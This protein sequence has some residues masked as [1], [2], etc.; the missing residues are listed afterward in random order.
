MACQNPH[1]RNKSRVWSFEE[2]KKT[3][4]PPTWKISRSN[5]ETQAIGS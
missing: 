1:S 2:N 3:H 5:P 4:F